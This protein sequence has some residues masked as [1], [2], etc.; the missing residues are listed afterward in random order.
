[1]CINEEFLLLFICAISINLYC[2]K[3]SFTAFCANIIDTAVFSCYFICS[4]RLQKRTPF[5]PGT[6]IARSICGANF[7]DLWRFL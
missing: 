5:H 2:Y 7:N 3:Q 6:D 4:K 1:M